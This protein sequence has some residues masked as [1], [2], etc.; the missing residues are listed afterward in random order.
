MYKS[1][2]DFTDIYFRCVLFEFVEDNSWESILCELVI[3]VWSSL[4]A[5]Y[6]PFVVIYHELNDFS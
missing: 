6:E 2:I 3:V 5:N 1:F 4:V